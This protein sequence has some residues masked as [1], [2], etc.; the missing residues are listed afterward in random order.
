M[1]PAT[2]AGRPQ[3]VAAGDG[4]G[5]VVWGEAGQIISR[6][7]WGTSPSIVDERADVPSLNGSAEQTSDTPVAGAGGDSSYV[8]VGF[9]EVFGTG[10][11]TQ[12]RVLLRRL[13][14]SQYDPGVVQADG[15]STPG[16]EGADQPGLAV[17]EYGT[18]V[19]TSEHSAS[20]QVFGTQITGSGAAGGTARL[21]SLGS[22]TSADPVPAMAGLYSDL[23]AWQHDPGLGGMP[24]IRVRYADG[25]QTF[26]PELV[27]SSPAQ[28]PTDAAAGL[29]AGGD[30]DG[31]AAV[32]WVQG[33][34]TGARLMAGELYRAPGAFTATHSRTYSRSHHPVLQW[35]AARGKWGPVR[36]RVNVDGRFVGET[37]ATSLRVPATLRG[38]PAQLA[39]HRR[40]P[41]RRAEHA[42]R[43][44]ES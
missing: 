19:M 34:G 8:D 39:G 9:R 16:A 29:A 33:S 12:S 18:G 41:R 32:V 24:E 15:L 4:V 26:G 36:Y 20:H 38:R 2:G 43:P 42:P 25:G 27:L 11:S 1:T 22:A 17:G 21:D 14:G 31:D 6:R 3:A 13:R 37:T 10:V 7:V 5:I 30:V 23:V 35:Y 44:R 28:G 40:Q